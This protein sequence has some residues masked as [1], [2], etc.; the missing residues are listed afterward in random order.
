MIKEISYSKKWHKEN[1]NWLC[2]SANLRQVLRE[3]VLEDLRV[4]EG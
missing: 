4:A 2:W 1:E 3:G